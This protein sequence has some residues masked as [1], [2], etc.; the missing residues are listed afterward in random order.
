[1]I[2]F[3]AGPGDDIFSPVAAN[4]K[5]ENVLA[6]EP[7]A[8][9]VPAATNSKDERPTTLQSEVPARPRPGL[10]KAMENPRISPMTGEMDLN[11]SMAMRIEI[12]N[13]A[14]QNV[15]G[16]AVENVELGEIPLRTTSS[17]M[18]KPETIENQINTSITQTLKALDIAKMAEMEQEEKSQKKSGGLFSRFRKSS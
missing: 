5:D 1:M 8:P 15:A 16:M 3:T 2:H 9:V 11:A 18:E 7:E 13:K 12:L 17:G 4:D 6:L 10:P 14:K